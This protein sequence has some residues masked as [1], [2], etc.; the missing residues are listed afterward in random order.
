MWIS[1]QFAVRYPQTLVECEDGIGF[2][3]Q[4]RAEYPQG[5]ASNL[6]VDNSTNLVLDNNPI[7]ILA[8]HLRNH[9]SRK[10][11]ANRGDRPL[12]SPALHDP[13]LL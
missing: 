1:Q 12:S 10:I 3:L 8:A 2:A 6:A 7:A 13:L 9:F 11:L 4:S 5:I